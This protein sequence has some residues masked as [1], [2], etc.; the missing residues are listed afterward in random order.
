MPPAASLFVALLSTS[1]SAPAAAPAHSEPTGETEPAEI[2]S[3][4]PHGA[5]EIRDLTAQLLR[6]GDYQT[7]LP[8]E[9]KPP[10]RVSLHWLGLLLWIVLAVA[11]AVVVL[12]ALVWLARRL[13]GGRVDAEVSGEGASEEPVAIPIASAEALAA[14]GRWAEAIHALLLKTLEAL[15]AAARLAPSLTSREIVAQVRVA[16]RAREALAGLVLAVELSRFGGASADAADYARC[17]ERFHDFLAWYRS[18]A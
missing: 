12:L 10:T 6:K 15:S 13:R 14:D 9:W 16:P 11:L 18:A 17:L 3:V 7:S 2:A 5:T 8:A 1:L 4:S